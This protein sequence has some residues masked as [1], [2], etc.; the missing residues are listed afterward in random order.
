MIKFNRN[1]LVVLFIFLFGVLNAQEQFRIMTY[2]VLNYPSKI[3]ATR[4]PYFKQVIDVINPDIIVVQEMESLTGVNL[5]HEQVLDTL[6][7]AGDFINGT[8]DTENALFYKKNKFNFLS[9]I[10]I[11][12]ALRDISQLTFEYKTTGD[13][14]I[15]YSVH[16]KASTGTDNEQKR[17]AE[18]QRLRE[19]TDQLSIE[20][21]YIVAGDFNIYNAS[22]PAFQELIDQTSTGYFLDPINK[23]GAWHNSTAYRG[24]H[25]Q[26]TRTTNLSDEGSTGGLDDRFD[27]IMVSQ[28][29]IDSG[30]IF[31]SP[32]SY[33]A[34]GNDGNHLNRALIELPNAFVSDEIATAL[35]YSSDHLPVYADFEIQNLT[36]VKINEIL[37]ETF[38]LNQNF[39][40]PFNP[41]TIIAYSIPNDVKN[42]QMINLSVYNSLGEKIEVLVDKVQKSGVHKLN[43]NASEYSSGL[44]IYVLRSESK[45][46]SKKMLLI[47]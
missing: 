35:Y 8:F 9:N 47:K 30:G 3:S 10:P 12:T 29:V 46:L 33:T 18:V 26:S 36:D 38:T 22:E 6:Y 41:S 14:I 31:Y 1:I 4:N 32:G 23:V 15:V 17:L 45:I 16:L 42:G 27:M 34:L 20:S 39:P 7:E 13:T 40:N 2:N 21:N 25:T 28:A 19:V 44:Y 11:K 5:F 24:I 37:Y 43:F